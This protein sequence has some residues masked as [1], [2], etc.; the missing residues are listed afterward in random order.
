MGSGNPGTGGT[1]SSAGGSTQPSAQAVS[2]IE[3]T[4]S[5]EIRVLDSE[6][7]CSK[8]TPLSRFP[9]PTDRTYTFFGLTDTVG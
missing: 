9:N 5:A 2:K 6:N 3:S 7:Q 4:I 8:S 1:A